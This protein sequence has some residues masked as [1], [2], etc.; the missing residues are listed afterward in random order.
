MVSYR[1][2]DEL[3]TAPRVLINAPLLSLDGGSS[4]H[5]LVTLLATE[6]ER[7]VPRDP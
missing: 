1:P 2:G 5:H 6:G 4:G 7:L 3:M